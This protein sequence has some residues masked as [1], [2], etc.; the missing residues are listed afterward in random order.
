M[1]P[2]S[3]PRF[4]KAPPELVGR[5]NAVLERL[6]GPD[7][8]RRAMFG[9]PCAWVA[10]N[11]ATGLFADEWWVRVSEPDREAVLAMPGGHPFQVMPGRDMGR[12][13][14]LPDEVVADDA[15]LDH[16]LGRAF[17]FTRTLPAKR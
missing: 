8:T 16:W 5:F 13:V 11:M 14:V 10:G 3:M 6:A 15:L 17:S 4:E 1:P 9:Y 2:R 12:Y 7:V